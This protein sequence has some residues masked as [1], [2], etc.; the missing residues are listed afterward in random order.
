[1][2]ETAETQKSFSKYISH[3]IEQPIHELRSY[4]QARFIR[5]LLMV[6]GDIVP[7]AKCHIAVHFVNNVPKAHVP[8]AGIH[9]HKCDEV[10]LILGERGA[11]TYSITM[12]KEEHIVKSPAAVFVPKRLP[13]RAEAIAGSG[14]LVAVLL[15]P[16]REKSL[17]FE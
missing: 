6:S 15:T 2:S 17:I 12:G 8:Y 14:T 7:D 9:A 5:R 10:Y 16:S 1:M 4:K 11:L 3:G 13:H